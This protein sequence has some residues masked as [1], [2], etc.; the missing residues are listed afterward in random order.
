EEVAVPK[1]L[2]DPVHLVRHLTEP[3]DVRTHSALDAT[4]GARRSLAHRSG[5]G[6]TLVACEAPAFHQ[7]AMHVQQ[8][9]RTGALMQIVDVLRDEQQ[10][11]RPFGIE[12]RQRAVSGIRLRGSKLRAPRIVEGVDERWIAAIGVRGAHVLDPVSLPQ[13]IRATKG[14]K[15]ALG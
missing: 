5:P 3:D 6:E 2:V 1:R 11:A 10:L 12:L 15:A 9:L 13:T 8:P 4:R 7:L 14:R